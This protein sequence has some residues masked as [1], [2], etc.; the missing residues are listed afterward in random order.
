MS[1][2]VYSIWQIVPRCRFIIKL[3]FPLLF[4][5]QVLKNCREQRETTIFEEMNKFKKEY[6]SRGSGR[7]SV[8]FCGVFFLCTVSVDKHDSTVIVCS[9]VQVRERI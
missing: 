4:S 2:K 9:A 7:G 5:L 8:V 1:R 6:Y 3:K